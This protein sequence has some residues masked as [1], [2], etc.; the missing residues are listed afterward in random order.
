MNWHICDIP[1]SVLDRFG[2]ISYDIISKVIEV[3]RT[4]RD[5][6]RLK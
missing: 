1:S 4:F 3:R 5:K 2:E 6:S